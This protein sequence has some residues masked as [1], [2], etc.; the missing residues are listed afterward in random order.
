MKS[1]SEGESPPEMVMARGTTDLHMEELL[2]DDASLVVQGIEF[3]L[4]LSV[5]VMGRPV[6]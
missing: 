6:L 1:V 4:V 2:G 5:V 3:L